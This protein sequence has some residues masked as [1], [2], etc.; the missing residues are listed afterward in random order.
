MAAGP[1]LGHYCAS[2]MRVATRDTRRATAQ[3]ELR[4]AVG[5]LPAREARLPW[6]WQG[7]AGHVP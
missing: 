6:T 3:G 7:R 5:V 2:A 1:M 4:R